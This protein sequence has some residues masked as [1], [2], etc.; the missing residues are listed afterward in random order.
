[1]LSVFFAFFT[2]LYGIACIVIIE[3]FHI[4]YMK[5]QN[6]IVV[7]KAANIVANTMDSMLNVDAH[8]PELLPPLDSP[9]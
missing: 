3:L 2:S 7:W 6:G 5:Q 1:M 9:V 4:E 8:D